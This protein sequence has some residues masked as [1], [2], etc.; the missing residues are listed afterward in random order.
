ML[1]E[2][3]DCPDV[4]LDLLV[5]GTPFEDSVIARRLRVS[6]GGTEVWLASPED[7]VVYKLVAGRPH[8]YADA[9]DVAIAVGLAGRS[10]DWNYVDFWCTEFAVDD[11][12]RGL[13]ERVAG[14]GREE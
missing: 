12:A 6:V 9:E 1:L 5:V 3:V 10:I 7:L 13:R 8:D 14:S 11:R 2:R 4:R